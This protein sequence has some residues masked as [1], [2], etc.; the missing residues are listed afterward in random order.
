MKM[1]LFLIACFLGGSVFAGNIK[2]SAVPAKVKAY[3]T[4]HYPAATGMEWDY[5]DDDN[6]Y[7]AEFKIKGLEYKLEITPEGVLYASKEDLAV[8]ALPE[9]ITAY[10]GQNYP[11]YRILGA[12][13]KMKAGKV[14]YDVGIKGKNSHGQTRHHNIYFNEKGEVIKK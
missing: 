14:T 12:N 9:T 13:K 4:A 1:Y 7:E 2:E 5:D 8:S 6:V 3:V 11:D 10:I